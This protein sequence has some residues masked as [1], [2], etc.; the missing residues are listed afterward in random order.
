MRSYHLCC[1]S[2]A[3][4]ED[5][6]GAEK[7]FGAKP[8]SSGE[9]SLLGELGNVELDNGDLAFLLGGEVVLVLTPCRAGVEGLDPPCCAGRLRPGIFAVGGGVMPV[10]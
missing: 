3:Y 1:W 7:A 9:R 6:G 10:L 5:G 2:G 8:G 4:A